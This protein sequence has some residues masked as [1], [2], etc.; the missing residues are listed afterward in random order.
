MDMEVC[1]SSPNDLMEPPQWLVVEA[2]CQMT[3]VFM[4]ATHAFLW[5]H[6]ILVTCRVAVMW[7]VALGLIVWFFIGLEIFW[8]NCSN[9][10]DITGSLFMAFSLLAG[11]FLTYRNMILIDIVD[12]D[13]CIVLNSSS[14]SDDNSPKLR[15]LIV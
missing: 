11:L 4:L 14:S 3:L 1:Q 13:N 5:K 12:K 2:S 15:L 9:T 7:V 10:Y 6:I 8:V